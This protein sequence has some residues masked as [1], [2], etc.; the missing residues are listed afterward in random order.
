[1]QE[2]ALPHP[3]VPS[4]QGPAAPCAAFMS[5]GQLRNLKKSTE[6]FPYS[7]FQGDMDQ[8]LREKIP[9]LPSIDLT[10]ASLPLKSP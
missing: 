3:A 7:W 10:L 9:P 4:R 8:A 2:Q 6:I 1:M 5:R